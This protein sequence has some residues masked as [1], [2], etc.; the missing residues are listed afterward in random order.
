MS[1]SRFTVSRARQTFHDG[2]LGDVAECYVDYLE[3]KNFA[4][5]TVATYLRAATHFARWLVELPIG[6]YPPV[7]E[8]E[9]R[10]FLSTHLEQCRCEG[11]QQRSVHICRAALRHL[12]VVLRHCGTYVEEPARAPSPVVREV[13]LFDEHLRD[14]CGVA[15]QTRLHRT[16]YVRDFLMHLFGESAVKHE[17]IRPK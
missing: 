6:V 14:V 7:H 15:Q 3:E 16:R 8:R 17:Q 2:I 4:V 12:V 11:P 9:V 10:E 5:S 1:S 13:E